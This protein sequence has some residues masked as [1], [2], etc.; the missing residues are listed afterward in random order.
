MRENKFCI[1]SYFSVSRYIKGGKKFHLQIQQHFQTHMYVN[2]PYYYI[3]V[4]DTLIDSRMCFS[5]CSMQYY[6]SFM[7]NQ[8]EKIELQKKV[9]RRICVRNITF[10]AAR[11]SLYIIFF[12]FF[13]L[14]PALRLF[15]F[16]VEKMFL[17]QKMW[18]VVRGWLTSL[19]APQQTDPNRTFISN[20]KILLVKN[21][22]RCG[23]FT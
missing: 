17:L 4:S 13:S 11:P 1:Y 6:Q 23:V 2:N 3:V 21:Y 8:K 12:R 10:L 16:F 15:Q 7:R 14:L 20:V 19:L 5:C 18:W 22:I 9:H